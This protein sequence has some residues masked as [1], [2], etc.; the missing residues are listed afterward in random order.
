MTQPLTGPLQAAHQALQDLTHHLVAIEAE[1]EQKRQQLRTLERLAALYQVDQPA[2]QTFM[3]KPYLLRPLKGDRFELIIPRFVPFR[4]GW[5]VRVDGEFL[6]FEVTRFINIIAPLPDWLQAE[7]GYDSPAFQAHLEGDRL[8]VDQGD[9]AQVWKRLGGS[10]RFTT[11]RDNEL[12]LRPKSR[13]DLI[14]ELVRQGVL[15]F[16]TRPIPPQYLREPHVGYSLRSH[17]ARDFDIFLDH[18]ALSV[19]APGGAGKTYLGVYAAA[20]LTGP[21]MVLAPKKSI[22]ENWKYT[23]ELY[24]P[25]LLHEIEFRTYQWVKARG[26]IEGEYVLIIYDEA[27]RLPADMGIAAAQARTI[28]RIGLS[29]SPVREDG[30]DDLIPALVAGP[31]V[32][33]DWPSGEAPDAT[34]WLVDRPEDKFDVVRRLTERPVDGKTLIFVYRLEIGRK[35]A[36][37]LSIPFVSGQTPNQLQVIQDND[38]VV[39]SKVGDEGIS[40]NAVRVI[41]ADFLG[42]RAEEIQRFY[43]AQHARR[44]GEFHTILTKAEFHT[45]RKRLLMLE[46][47]G[48]KI[49]VVSDEIAEPARVARRTHRRPPLQS[50]VP[51][52]P[53]APPTNGNQVTTQP[54][55][56]VNKLTAVKKQV[57]R[58]GLVDKIWNI[59]L[60]AAVVSPEEIAE[61]WGSTSPTTLGCI[62]AIVKALAAHKLI[63]FVSENRYQLNQEEVQRLTV[64]GELSSAPKV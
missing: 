32:G 18:S 15:P 16:T 6:V 47:K 40:V 1:V 10:K 21:K 36:Q 53:S 13:F 35:Y 9:P 4:A 30:A 2:F 37:A 43:R 20:C 34:V 60:R 3:Q 62:R 11:R 17:Q 23:L 55:P 64:L 52:T 50:Q 5:P 39:V 28:T 46:A 8:I 12:L 27:H 7:L 19:Y 38:T 59:Y 58:P 31:C 33:F 45:H 42:G 29:A 22:L 44:K 48:I 63:N 56:L 24:A 25:H 57:D 26:G 54:A 14:R 61:A 51:P 49:Q 41:E